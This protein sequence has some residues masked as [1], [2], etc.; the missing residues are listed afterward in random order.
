[1]VPLLQEI[2]RTGRVRSVDE[3]SEIP[4]DSAV[5]AD[6]GEFLQGLIT[7]R[8]AKC[9]LEIGLA[10][11]VSALF[12]CEALEKNGGMRHIAIDPNQ[13]TQWQGI[14]INNL[15]LAGFAGLAELHELPAHLALASLE[16]RGTRVE[17]AFIDGWHTFDYALTDF[18]HVDRLLSVGGVVVFDDAFF[19]GV[20]EVCRYV[21]TNH[22]YRVIGT[23]ERVADYRPSRRT[24]V[25]RWAARR[26]GLARKLLKSKFVV[27][28]ENLGFTPDCR[29]VAFEK[30]REDTRGWADHHEF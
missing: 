7:S 8:Q 2:L 3:S 13:S 1:M 6:V 20:H 18:F 12:I 26:S 5:T 10:Y 22:A 21:A 19:P 16:S 17:F 28:D 15:R 4:L 27:P 30:L 23:T 14:G 9:T 11:G 24:R 25:A 29:C